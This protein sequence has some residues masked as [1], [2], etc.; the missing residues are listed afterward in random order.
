MLPGEGFPTWP[1]VREGFLERP[2]SWLW[3]RMDWEWG[4]VRPGALV[5][6]K[7]GLSRTSPQCPH[8]ASPPGADV[9]SCSASWLPSLWLYL[10][11]SF[12]VQALPPP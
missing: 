3:T 10:C 8:P 7:Q 1:G 11:R 12:C 5:P 6:G 9:T 2:P 4:K